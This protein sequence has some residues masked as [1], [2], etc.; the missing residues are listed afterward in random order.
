MLA[1]T[2]ESSRRIEFRP[3]FGQA[4]K[5][6]LSRHA[7]TGAVCWYVDRE[8]LMPIED[9]SYILSIQPIPAQRFHEIAETLP[10]DSTARENK[11]LYT[12]ACFIEQSEIGA[13]LTRVGTRHEAMV[14]MAVASRGSGDAADACRT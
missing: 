5:L 10:A 3:S 13:P 11:S 2:G 1:F 8:T 6:P 12:L 14:R 7:I 4:V 9:M